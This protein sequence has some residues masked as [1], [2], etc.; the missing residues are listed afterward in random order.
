MWKLLEQVEMVV[1]N[2]V[3]IGEEDFNMVEHIFNSCF[4]QHH[5]MR[6]REV[7]IQIQERK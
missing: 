7:V 4:G 2:W 3:Q 5:V 6:K 1:N